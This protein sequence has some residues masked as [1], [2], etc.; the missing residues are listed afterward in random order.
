MTDARIL[1]CGDYYPSE[2]I[3]DELNSGKEL[4]DKNFKDL[5]SKAN[6]SIVNLECPV[7][8]GDSFK[9]AQK[10]GPV[11]QGYPEGVDYLKKE[12][13]KMVTLANNHI[14]DYGFD[15]LRSTMSYLKKNSI[16]Y[17]GAGLYTEEVEKINIISV[18]D[19]TIGV[20]NVCEH[21]FSVVDGNS[22]GA[23]PLDVASVFYN[24]RELKNQSD[25]IL[26]IV[27][28]GHEHYQL[29]SPRMKK[30]Y[31][32]FIDM[33]VDVVINSHQHC[34]SGYEE[35]NSKFI[36]YGLGNFIFSQIDRSE[37]KSS[38]NEGIAILLT[39]K[40]NKDSK[41]IGFE[42]W[43]YNQCVGGVNFC[44]YP[45]ESPAH[46]KVNSKIQEINAIIEDDSKLHDEFVHMAYLRRYHFLM[47]LTSFRSRLMKG[48]CYRKI[49]P[50][51]ISKRRLLL[52]KNS[53]TCESHLDVFRE[54]INS[55]LINS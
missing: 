51:F 14:L 33:G 13:F 3:K 19:Y 55:N 54:F 28:G 9:K 10:S 53:I 31:R 34:F 36:F 50:H 40:K 20:I 49:I 7:F 39:L 15:G 8:D 22:Y 30:L 21:E 18:G 32:L 17:V 2:I 44:L 35:Y 26:L 48:L 38:W 5:L 29:P 37:T 4:F 46:Q 11:L 16:N 43:P 23:N 45:K 27:H 52:A 47:L 6:Y 42:I 24:I 12:G 41:I 1:I 25:F